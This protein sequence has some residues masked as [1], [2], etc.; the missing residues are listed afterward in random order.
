MASCPNCGSESVG[1]YCAECGQKMR[2]AH[3]LRAFAREVADDQ[4]GIDAKLPRTL[5]ALFFKPGLLTTE[6]MAGRIARYIPPFRLYL[7]AS[8]L[9]FVLLSF[10]SG[11][12][13]WAE[14]AA[15]EI[16]NDTSA[17][18]QASRP[19]GGDLNVGVSV[20]GERWL[21]SVAIDIPWQWL[22]QKVEANLEALGKLP[23]NVALRTVW[24]AIVEEMAKVMFV[25]L[26]VY[27]L[28]LKL[29]YIR[30]RRYYIEHFIFALHI[31]AFAFALFTTMLFYRNDWFVLALAIIVAVYTLLAMKRVYGQGPIKTFMK[32]ATLGFAYMIIALLGAF[33]AAL[34]AIAS[35][36]A[37]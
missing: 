23:P 30:R 22:D 19:A 31:H 21:D 7:L 10:L 26:P 24:N 2:A 8:V 37:V 36:S 1:N 25:L 28:L 5:K 6:Y 9:F 14:Q 32:W 16:G 3:S 15:R 29:I 35:T 11:R 33:L 13:D 34:V 17:A 27:A 12:S 18:A 4:L 20:R